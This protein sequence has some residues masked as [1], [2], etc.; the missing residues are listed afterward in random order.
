MVTTPEMELI[1]QYLVKSNEYDTEADF[2]TATD[3][4]DKL[5]NKVKGTIKLNTN[6]IGKALA[7]FNFERTQKRV[8]NIP[9]KGYYVK[10]N[11]T[12]SNL[13]LTPTKNTNENLQLEAAFDGY[14]IEK[15]AHWEID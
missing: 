7:F 5:S 10:V 14:E 8:N 6:N 9:M 4:L 15:P 3:I 11:E 2:L 1:M 12:P 13:E